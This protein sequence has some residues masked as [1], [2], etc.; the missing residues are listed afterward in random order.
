MFVCKTAQVL[1]AKL[2]LCAHRASGPTG[3]R[4]G[5]QQNGPV[6]DN[7]QQLNGNLVDETAEKAI[8]DILLNHI[9]KGPGCS[10]T[11]KNGSITAV[12]AL[13]VEVLEMATQETET[14]RTFWMHLQK[15]WDLRN[16]LQ[17]RLLMDKV[18]RRKIQPLCMNILAHLVQQRW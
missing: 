16:S 1:T 15:N 14:H 3:D 7:S 11:V 6:E 4:S 17:T 10:S 13:G 8:L 9:F 12:S 5:S 2:L 18:N